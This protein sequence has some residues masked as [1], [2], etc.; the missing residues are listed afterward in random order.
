[1]SHLDIITAAYDRC[2]IAYVVKRG[3][4]HSFLILTGPRL[5]T[6]VEFMPTGDAC[7]GWP[8]IEFD[9]RGNVASY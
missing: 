3:E 6:V 7:R 9:E 2:G 5:K 8:F 4:K 1:M